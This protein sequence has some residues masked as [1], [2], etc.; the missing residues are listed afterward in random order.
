MKTFKRIGSS[1]ASVCDTLDNGLQAVN[2]ATKIVDV[3]LT[4]TFIDILND[5]HSNQAESGVSLEEL[6]T[7]AEK[8]KS[9]RNI[10]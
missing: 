3:V 1:V 5:M 6:K 9:I 7:T 8:S 10:W 4:Q 2:T